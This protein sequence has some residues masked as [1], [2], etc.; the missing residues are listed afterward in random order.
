[1]IEIKI[2]NEL[3][4]NKINKFLLIE[5]K[6]FKD[7]NKIGWTANNLISQLQKNNNV[8]LGIFDKSS[9]KGFLIGDI[10][11]QGSSLDFELYLIY[12]SKK[13]RR[14]NYASKLLNSLEIKL[15]N[16]SIKR[17]YLEVSELNTAAIQFYEKNNFV[18]FK[19]RHNYYKY[20]NIN[21]NAKCY[22]KI[23][24]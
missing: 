8:A 11:D 17:I 2:L 14:M 3:D 22:L 7:F 9:L 18:F 15:K 12:I 6:Y 20:K 1:M 24:N 4:I 10:V 16:L 23:Y 5:K 21:I 19:F 13:N